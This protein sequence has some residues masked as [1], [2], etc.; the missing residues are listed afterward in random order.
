M[1]PVFI[2]SLFRTGSTYVWL[3][4]RNNEQYYCYY[5]PFNEVL[6]IL[7]T[8]VSN[9]LNKNI[10][11][12]VLGHPAIKKRY[13]FE[14]E[15]LL[16]DGVPGVPNFKKSFTFDDFYCFEEHIDLKNYIN[17]LISNTNGKIPVFQFNRSAL[18]VKWFKRQ[19]SNSHNIYLL[20]NPR[21]NWASYMNHLEKGNTY[22]V[23]MDL[24]L[25]SLN[26]K[27]TRFIKL[28]E[29]IPLFEYHNKDFGK[30][31]VFY[32]QITSVYS[33]KEKYWIFYYI[34]F[35]AL[36]E[37][38][39]YSD[40]IL[41]INRIKKDLFYRKKIE[42]FLSSNGILN[43]N[44][45]DANI[46]EY[47]SYPLLNKIMEDI[48][49]EVQRIVLQDFGADQKSFFEKLSVEDCNYLGFSRKDFFL[50]SNSNPLPSNNSEKIIDKSRQIIEILFN[51]NLELTE[52]L[53]ERDARLAERDARLAERDA[54]IQKI[55]SSTSWRVTAPLRK[56]KRLFSRIF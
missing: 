19:F 15:K 11:V 39:L 45:E 31:F 21:D 4:F 1:A 46:K 5:E 14:Y 25:A 37:N 50:K 32:D 22:F 52:Q 10:A 17:F 23:K 33:T 49:N 26:S 42:D 53:A 34:W 18:R 51:R 44:F 27:N 7:T 24:L 41:N 30:E 55:Y 8:D 35:T 13:F 28:S 29:A 43:I 12:D 2:H 36:I 20:R 47:S 9:L 3:K 48:E 54:R 40:L 16:T 6:S 56:I 38:V